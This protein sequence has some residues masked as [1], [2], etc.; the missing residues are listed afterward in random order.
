MKGAPAGLSFGPSMGLRSVSPLAGGLD[1]T[2][3]RPGEGVIGECHASLRRQE[4]SVIISRTRAGTLV[5][6]R[7]SCGEL[8]AL[9]LDA[10]SKIRRGGS[11]LDDPDRM[12]GF[13]MGLGFYTSI[14]SRNTRT[15]F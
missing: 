13:K 3:T 10:G 1:S 8:R 9:S 5:D 4:R 14:L 15:M 12:D 6:V 7:A 11:A 2:E